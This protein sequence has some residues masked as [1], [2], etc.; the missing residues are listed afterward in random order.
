MK[1]IT[2][3]IPPGSRRGTRFAVKP[4]L[5]SIRV[6][7]SPTPKRQISFGEPT[8]A[9]LLHRASSLPLSPTTE[10]IP[11]SRDGSFGDYLHREVNTFI[12]FLLK[13]KLFFQRPR[14]ADE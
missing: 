2:L 8:R 12:C 7:G 4:L 6:A 13:T 3:I 14:G 11:A 9:P 10:I 5:T 1:V